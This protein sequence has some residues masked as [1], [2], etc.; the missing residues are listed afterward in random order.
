LSDRDTRSRSRSTVEHLDGDLLANLDD[1]GRVVDVLPGQLGDVHEAVDAAE[2]DERA[3]V[4]DR[5]DDTLADLTL[6]SWL[7]NSLRTSDWVCSS[8]ARD[9][10]APRCCGSCRAR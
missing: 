3:E 2:V 9:A 10:T 7:R 8:H 5:R 1:L 4:D 6:G